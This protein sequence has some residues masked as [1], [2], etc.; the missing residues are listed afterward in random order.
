MKYDFDKVINRIGTGS[1]KFD[2]VN[3]RG[4]PCDILPMWVADMDFPAPAK[5]LEDMKQAVAHGIFGYTEPMADYFDAVSGWFQTRFG[6]T[7]ERNE[8]VLTPGIVY[9]LAQMV[10]AYTKAGDSVMIQTPVYY[11]FYDII[12][13]NDRQVVK[14]PL[15]YQEGNYTIDFDDF[16]NKIKSENVKLFILCNPHNPVGRVFTKAELMRISE[17]SKRYGVIIA[18][19][20]IHCDF[21]YPEYEHVTFGKINEDSIICTAP[22][23]T[24]NLAGLQVSNIFIKNENLR[25]KLKRQINKSGYS[26]LNTLGLVACRSAYKNGAEWLDQLKEYL[27]GN[28]SFT[29]AFLNERLPKVKLIPPQGTYLLWLDFSEYNLP[30]KQLDRLIV[31]KAKLWLDSGVMFGEDGHG[32]QRINIACPRKTLEIALLKLEKSLVN[33]DEQQ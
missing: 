20:E 8:I 18:A 12:R 6:Y 4:K 14:N 15:I 27:Y 1:I 30:Q 10:L 3:E 23:K 33:A 16:E 7:V 26:Q 13:D 9:A 32:F 17:I 25:Q 29:K 28:I 5:V 24:F 22:S 19:D 11:P 2:F 21:V 31:H